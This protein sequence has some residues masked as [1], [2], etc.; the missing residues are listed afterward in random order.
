M[1][2]SMWFTFKPKGDSTMRKFIIASLIALSLSACTSHVVVTVD[3]SHNGD[4]LT[5]VE[6]TKTFLK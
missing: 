1:T 3:R 2:V 6:V 4:Q 5:T